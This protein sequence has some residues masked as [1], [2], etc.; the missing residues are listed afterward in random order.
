MTGNPPDQPRAQENRSLVIFRGLVLTQLLISRTI[1]RN[2]FLCQ[3]SFASKRQQ[4]DWPMQE[5]VGPRGPV[6]LL[7][8]W[9]GVE[10]SSRGSRSPQEGLLGHCSVLLLDKAA[11]GI[12]RCR[13]LIKTQTAG[14]KM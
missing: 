1:L 13:P 11:S 7:V 9:V 3:N 10:Q 4:H 14:T 6:R 2:R 5:M 12:L 8:S